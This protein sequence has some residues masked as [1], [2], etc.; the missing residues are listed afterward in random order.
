MEFDKSELHSISF[1]KNNNINS[2]TDKIF[3]IKE[4]GVLNSIYLES[5]TWLNKTVRLGDTLALNAPVIYPLFKDVQVKKGDK[6]RLKMKY[7]FGNG[8]RN[9]ETYMVKL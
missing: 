1:N 3:E 9:L 8:Y 2:K 4:D 7:M 5:E 6:V